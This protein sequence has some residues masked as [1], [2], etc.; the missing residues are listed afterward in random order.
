[1]LAAVQISQADFCST[2]R[3]AR[4]LA[5]KSFMRQTDSQTVNESIQ[6]RCARCPSTADT[7][8]TVDRVS[9]KCFL[10]KGMKTGLENPAYRLARHYLFLQEREPPDMSELTPLRRAAC[11]AKRNAFVILVSCLHPPRLGSQ[12]SAARAQWLSRM[13]RQCLA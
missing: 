6:N 8:D 7:I 5:L 11:C 12:R 2:D 10:L 4:R 13:R 3:S 1:M 9:S